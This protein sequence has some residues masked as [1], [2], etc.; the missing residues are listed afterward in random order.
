MA[1]GHDTEVA[2]RTVDD[3]STT[4]AWVVHGDTCVWLLEVPYPLTFMAWLRQQC[5]FPGRIHDLARDVVTDP[6][7]ADLETIHQV[8]HYLEARGACAGALDTLKDAVRV[9]NVTY[10]AAEERRRKAGQSTYYIGA[11]ATEQQGALSSE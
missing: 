6:G 4:P 9:W 10:G 7:T 3:K 11:D 2:R 8:R 5:D 1:R